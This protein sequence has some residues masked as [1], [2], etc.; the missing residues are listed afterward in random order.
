MSFQIAR[1]KFLTPDMLTFKIVWIFFFLYRFSN[2]I[3]AKQII[4]HFARPNWRKVF[5]ELAQTHDQHIIG[6][7]YV[8][9][10]Y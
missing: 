9:L 7:V 8:L 10:K 5:T 6:D 3:K 2:N 4:T 1:Y